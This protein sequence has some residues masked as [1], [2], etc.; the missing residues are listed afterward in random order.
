G[1]EHDWFHV[2]DRYQLNRED[3]D[4]AHLIDSFFFDRAT[5]ALPD[6]HPDAARSRSYFVYTPPSYDP[7][8]PM[9]LVVLL[10]GRSSNAISMALITEM[11]DV[12]KRHG[13]IVVYPQGLNNEWNAI[14]DLVHQR[15]VSPQDDV[16]FLKRLTE[17]LS[18]DLNIDRR[19]M[20]IG[21]FS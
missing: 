16:A 11:N 7:S 17:D 15:G 12:A 8:R 10:H 5:F 20:F 13:F 4:T 9:P 14:F 3:V 1:G 2:G 18:V 19:R 21:G 6:P